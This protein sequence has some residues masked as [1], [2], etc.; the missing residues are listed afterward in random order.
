MRT[1]P[2]PRNKAPE[3]WCTAGKVERPVNVFK[4]GVLK[5]NVCVQKLFLSQIERGRIGI[6]GADLTMRYRR[7]KWMKREYGRKS[8]SRCLCKSIKTGEQ[9][10]RGECPKNK[11][12]LEVSF[13]NVSYSE[14]PPDRSNGPRWRKASRNR[15]GHAGVRAIVCEESDSLPVQLNIRNLVNDNI[16]VKKTLLVVVLLLGQKQERWGWWRKAMDC[17]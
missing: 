17:S 16:A 1:S 13:C 4:R 8:K 12:S 11:G 6:R 15:S 3:K 14:C 2:N 5:A 7:L 10:G 9:W